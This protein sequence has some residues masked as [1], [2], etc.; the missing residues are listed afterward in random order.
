MNSVVIKSSG[1]HPRTVQHAQVNSVVNSL[2]PHLR[3]RWM[4]GMRSSS[5][6][7]FWARGQCNG[8][9]NESCKIV[10]NLNCHRRQRTGWTTLQCM[11]W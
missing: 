9:M 7:A 6:A 1:M 11:R 3:V 10:S 2:K 5:G 8:I 4:L